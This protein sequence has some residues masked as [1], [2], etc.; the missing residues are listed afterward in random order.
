MP[1]LKSVPETTFPDAA[2][3]PPPEPPAVDPVEAPKALPE[4]PPSPGLALSPRPTLS[5]P[6]AMSQTAA[7]KP[8][9]IR[10]FLELKQP[11]YRTQVLETPRAACATLCQAHG[12]RA[13][14][15]A[16]NFVSCAMMV[17]FVAME[18]DGRIA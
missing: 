9:T 6:Q 1:F 2:P 7:H 4:S 12:S 15:L 11:T 14:M 16:P 17:S 10:I 5:E 8:A 13:R 18:P 3:L